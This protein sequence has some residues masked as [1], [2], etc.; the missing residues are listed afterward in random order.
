ML[1]L[2]LVSFL[3]WLFGFALTAAG[4]CDITTA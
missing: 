4:G 1:I 2:P 3:G